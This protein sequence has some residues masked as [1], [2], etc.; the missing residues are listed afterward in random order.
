MKTD[1]CLSILVH[2]F[3]D[4]VRLGLFQT[5]CQKAVGIQALIDAANNELMICGQEW[6]GSKLWR[7]VEF[8]SLKYGGLQN[9]TS[10]N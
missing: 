5:E 6:G 9:G 3:L 10:R 4:R 1:G 7:N 2:F 8:Q